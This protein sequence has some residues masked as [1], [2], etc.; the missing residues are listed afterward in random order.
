MMDRKGIKNT[1]KQTNQIKT[2]YHNQ[3]CLEQLGLA[4]KQFRCII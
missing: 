3:T 2:R 4:T 1:V